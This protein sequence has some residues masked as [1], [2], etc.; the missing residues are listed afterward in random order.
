M[1][2]QCSE[3]LSE[4]C[5]TDGLLAEKKED[6]GHVTLEAWESVDCRLLFGI[7]F[8]K[9][10]PVSAVADRRTGGR[11]VEGWSRHFW[12][13]RLRVVMSL[14]DEEKK[15]NGHVTF[16]RGEKEWSATSPQ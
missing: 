9:F 3:W 4:W 10:T 5:R 14:L 7:M 1:V 8:Y 2:C 6:D 16:R 13:R 15:D 11:E 12:K